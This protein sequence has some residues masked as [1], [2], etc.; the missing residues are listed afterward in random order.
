MNFCAQWSVYLCV[1]PGAFRFV[2]LL[3]RLQKRKLSVD[4]LCFANFSPRSLQNFVAIRNYAMR[5]LRV[6]LFYPPH[7]VIRATSLLEAEIL[8]VTRIS[9]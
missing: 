7:Y 9:G 8:R 2:E 3:I 6:L 5:F 1:Q 4:L